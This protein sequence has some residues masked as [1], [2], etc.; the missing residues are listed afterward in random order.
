MRPRD[1]GHL[2]C[3]DRRDAGGQSRP[4][5]GECLWSPLRECQRPG[6]E[7]TASKGAAMTEYQKQRRVPRITLPGRA[8]ARTRAIETVR[9][10]DVSLSGARVEHLNLLRPGA[11][12]SVEL[13]PALG[14]LVLAAQVVW[15]RVVG[16]EASPGGGAAAPLPERPPVLESHGRAAHHPGAGPGDGRLWGHLEQRRAVAVR[17]A[18][19]PTWKA[20]PPSTRAHSLGTLRR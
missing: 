12:C 8:A 17:R 19:I 14:A 15:S 13:P 11:P 9:L 10:L 4:S 18:V 20:G 2:G 16:A 3:D 6:G 5:E 7:D 1:R